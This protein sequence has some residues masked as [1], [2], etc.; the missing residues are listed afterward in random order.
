L[1][2]TYTTEFAAA[3]SGVQINASRKQACREAGIMLASYHLACL[4]NTQK[5]SQ[6]SS[7]MHFFRL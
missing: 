4:L 5:V 2:G 3:K 1:A 7:M 6:K